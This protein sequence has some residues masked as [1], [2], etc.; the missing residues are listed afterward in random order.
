MVAAGF[1]MGPRRTLAG[2]WYVLQANR[3]WAPVPDNDPASARDYMRRFYR[4]VVDTGWGVFDPV[5][6][7]G[8]EVEWWRVHREHQYGHAV[9]DELIGALDA[10]YA[11]VYD[12]PAGTMR[13]AAQRRA[14]AMDLSDAWVAAGCSLAD[15][16]LAQERRA[17]VASYTALREGVE[18]YG[19]AGRPS[20]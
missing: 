9:S 17:L 14:E 20:A 4:L 2:A 1:S 13:A 7:A 5:R 12:V 18:R 3:A 16:R 11:Y 15:P 10:L 8:L 19:S 6:A